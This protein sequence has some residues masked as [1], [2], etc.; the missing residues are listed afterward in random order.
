MLDLKLIQP[1]CTNPSFYIL[2]ILNHD[3]RYTL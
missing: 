2:P 1:N 3:L